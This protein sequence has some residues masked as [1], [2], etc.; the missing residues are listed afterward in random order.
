M[1]QRTSV[2]RSCACKT[3][4]LNHK[5]IAKS[6]VKKDLSTEAQ[7]ADPSPTLYVDTL[8]GTTTLETKELEKKGGEDNDH[9]CS[10]SVGN[11]DVGSRDRSSDI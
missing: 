4:P 3:R 11:D 8:H 1:N 2:L 6:R 5:S 10:R 9:T 7:S